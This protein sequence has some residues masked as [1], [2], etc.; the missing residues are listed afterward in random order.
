MTTV[1]ELRHTLAA[2]LAEEGRGKEAL[3]Q[4]EAALTEPG[5]VPAAAELYL[6]S[7]R[8]HERLGDTAQAFEAYL[9]SV[10]DSPASGDGASAALRLL[11]AG[12]E[13]TPGPRAAK[14]VQ[15]AVA[16]TRQPAPTALV[17]AGRLLH[18][19]GD[20]DGAS[21][22][23]EQ[24]L[25]GKLTD[26]TAVI[27][28]LVDVLL[29]SERPADARRVVDSH[30]ACSREA[31]AWLLLEEGRFDEACAVAEH[32]VA[33]DGQ[34]LP[35]EAVRLLAMTAL[36]Q[37]AEALAREEHRTGSADIQ[38]ARLV[39]HLALQQYEMAREAGDEV[40][41][42]VG[43]E[44]IA[45][46]IRAQILLEMA[47][48]L[49]SP[50][51]DYL[52]IEEARRSLRRARRVGQAG[53]PD[54]GARV[55]RHRW[56]RLQR[57]V[58]V[59]DDRFQYALAEAT[60]ALDTDASRRRAAVAECR[61][62][63]TTIVQDA[64]AREL[65]VQVLDPSLDSPQEQAAAYSAAV[66]ALV[67]YNQIERARDLAQRAVEVTPTS[68]SRCELA[69]L[70]WRSSYLETTDEPARVEH[71][72]TALRLLVESG[73]P[74]A[75]AVSR[76]AYL[77]GLLLAR[78]GELRGEDRALRSLPYLLAAS[79]AADDAYRWAN[80]AATLSELPARATALAC[81]QRASAIEPGDAFV[82]EQYLISEVNHLGDPE[83]TARAIANVPEQDKDAPWYT[84]VQLAIAL[85]N[86]R[87]SEVA[88]LLAQPQAQG[89]WAQWQVLQAEVLLGRLEPTS[90]RLAAFTAELE[91]SAD[92]LETL[93]EARRLMGQF[94]AADDAIS[95]AEH[96]LKPV[97]PRDAAQARAKTALL[98][99]PSG[100]GEAILAGQLADEISPGEL[101]GAIHIELPLLERQVPAVQPAAGRL[102]QVAE[103]RLH[104]LRR[105]PPRLT[106]DFTIVS[107]Q[108]ERAALT[109]QLLEVVELELS[110]DWETLADRANDLGT[111][112]AAAG[113]DEFL[114]AALAEARAGVARRVVQAVT[115]QLLNQTM[116][117]TQ[118]KQWAG[119]IEQWSAVLD[120]RDLLSR[121][122]AAVWLAARDARRRAAG[123]AAIPDDVSAPVAA[124][125]LAGRFVSLAAAGDVAAARE[126]YT[127]GLEFGSEP[128]FDDW[129]A[130]AMTST[131]TYPPVDAAL[132]AVERDGPA[133]AELRGAVA[134]TRHRVV[135]RLGELLGLDSLGTAADGQLLTPILVDLGAE[136]VPLVDP[137]QDDNVFVGELIPQLRDRVFTATGV[138]L[139]GIMLRPD[140]T[141][142]PDRFVVQVDEIPAARGSIPL[143]GEFMVRAAGPDDLPHAGGTA[144]GSAPHLARFHPLT[145]KTGVWA[146]TA[147]AG[148]QADEEARLSPAQLLAHAIEQALQPQLA[149]F[150]GP[151]EASDLV[152]EWS[153]SG[154]PDEVSAVIPDRDA[155]LALTWVLQAA[156][157]EGLS[158]ADWRKILSAIREAGGLPAPGDTLVDA[159]RAGLSRDMYQAAEWLS[160]KVPAELEGAVLDGAHRGAGPLGQGRNQLVAWVRQRSA[161]KGPMLTLITSSPAARAAVSAIVRGEF[162]MIQTVCD[163]D[164]AP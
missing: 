94:D 84:S 135:L 143:A 65:A 54:S 15:A 160:L 42:S 98:R 96:A 146:V 163:T 31:E 51:D 112:P 122:H 152:D 79:L 133:T 47:G 110:G 151:Q 141:L 125:L 132:D 16:R 87:E 5:E 78:L 34:G 61:L 57:S 128:S 10:T 156:V 69:D 118:V 148:S 114:S 89:S 6:A 134:A 103:S 37:P 39:A 56:M 105:S 126:A 49:D 107:D 139:P 73:S 104:E 76:H 149:R 88:E 115:G 53:R 111:G 60:V 119:R 14:A 131:E 86:G 12:T 41:R 142:P 136:L 106:E 138:H 162:E 154:D 113:A 43:T 83:L 1:R 13:I 150:L 40:A 153:S 44:P 30:Q 68:E 95:Q 144:A 9:K 23:L 121:A 7:G 55:L 161:E 3:E 130:R 21:A 102:R 27:D 157:R 124:E 22:A 19:T 81:S 72:E 25:A 100:D 147:A 24:A 8:L 123:R 2:A 45:L 137:S 66:S 46:V 91:A 75:G 120:D 159:I 129:A 116:A 80:L 70:A 20:L 63:G 155:R 36:G 18:H 109:R 140:E 93:A 90:G 17:L 99:D 101:L 71:L 38:F 50:P 11:A 48:S 33:A 35:T 32:V 59:H 85:R 77:Y 108:S 58:R 64:G 117:E 127:A 62:A 29:E 4:L 92:D 145:G 26:Q 67:Q 74:P 28:E 158:I 52:T 82:T 97:P 164:V